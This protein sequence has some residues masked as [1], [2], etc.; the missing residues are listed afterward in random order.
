MIFF[1]FSAFRFKSTISC[2]FSPLRLCKSVSSSCWVR[3]FFSKEAIA[4]PAPPLSFP[5]VVQAVRSCSFSTET[6]KFSVLSWPTAS[7]RRLSE[8]NIRLLKL[9]SRIFILAP[10]TQAL[11][12]SK[13]PSPLTHFAGLCLW[14][15]TIHDDSFRATLLL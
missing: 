7:I 5:P 2:E 1:C 15:L 8:R 11:H 14:S 3:S 12:R 10:L 13:S 9:V 6:L 4:K